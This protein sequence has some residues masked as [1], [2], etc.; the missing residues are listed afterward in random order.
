MCAQV[1]FIQPSEFIRSDL[2][3]SDVSVFPHT[4]MTKSCRLQ[5]IFSL[6]HTAK[7]FDRDRGAARDSR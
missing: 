1:R 4:H 2:D 7:A 6:F 5:D 3:A